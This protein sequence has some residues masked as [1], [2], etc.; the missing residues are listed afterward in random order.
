MICKYC[1]FA[2]KIDNRKEIFYC[3]NVN[4]E[5]YDHHVSDLEVCED[6]KEKPLGK[7]FAA[8]CL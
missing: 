4:C 7:G 5:F 2:I 6:Y 3:S 8:S 1:Y